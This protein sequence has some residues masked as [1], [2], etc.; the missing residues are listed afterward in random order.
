MIYPSDFKY[1]SSKTNK[2][3]NYFENS[4]GKLKN[5]N[6]LQL[7]HSIQVKPVFEVSK[8][9]LND[10]RSTMQPDIA[11]EY[12]LWSRYCTSSTVHGFKYIDDRNLHWYER[13]ILI[14]WQRAKGEK[15]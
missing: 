1:T 9:N 3:S 10:V 4:D 13:Y 6:H 7:V 11:N 5:S 2:G 14:V 15:A 8:K 12:S